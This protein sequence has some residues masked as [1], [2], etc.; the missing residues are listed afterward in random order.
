MRF[1]Q[2]L[3]KRW[4]ALAEEI[5]KFASI[6]GINVVVNMVIF[7]LLLPVGSLKATVVATTVATTSAYF[8]NR[9][10]TYR[11]LPKASLRREYTLFFLF[12]LV[13]LAIEVVIL[14]VFD[15]VLGFDRHT[16]V[17]AFNIAKFA[18]LAL[19]TL[20]RF[21]SYRSFVFKVAGELAP[22]A[23]A[24]SA[25]PAEAADPVTP[26]AP[27]SAP[28]ATDEAAAPVAT[29]A[30]EAVD[31]AFAEVLAREAAADLAEADDTTGT[32]RR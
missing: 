6:G 21:W 18:G 29:E 9:Y 1:L 7:N 12:N 24:P 22:A 13:G 15:Y 5:T 11:H 25:A 26:A 14:Y 28:P 19:G 10:W 16:D 8:M 23:T 3:P 20:F 31:S 32:R 2:R 30:S 4:R 27:V 17:L